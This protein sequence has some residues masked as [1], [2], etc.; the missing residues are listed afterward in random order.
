MALL[1]HTKHVENM[2]QKVLKVAK[3][4]TKKLRA[5]KKVFV[6]KDRENEGRDAY[7][8]GYF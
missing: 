3:D 8:S 1:R 6:D 5:I 4:K 7:S 2:D